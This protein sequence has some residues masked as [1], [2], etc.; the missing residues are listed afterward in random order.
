MAV[1]IV[2]FSANV[3][4]IVSMTWC[5]YKY[6]DST[7]L[8]YLNISG[9]ANIRK[10]LNKYIPFLH[11]QP[12]FWTFNGRVDSVVCVCVCWGETT[13]IECVHIGV[14]REQF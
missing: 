1:H 8:Q 10:R 9:D 11:D 3:S 14:L 6:S 4:N 7:H 12:Y 13:K 2:H 5:R